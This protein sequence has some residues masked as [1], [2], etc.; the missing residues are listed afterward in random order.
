M[1]DGVEQERQPARVVNV[2]P[3][4]QYAF[5]RE[6]RLKIYESGKA[7]RLITV[8]L[9]SY[10]VE[11]IDDPEELAMISLGSIGSDHPWEEER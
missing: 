7:S 5:H 9:D 4:L 11:I 8:Y 6:A 10:R 3:M 2:L 1:L